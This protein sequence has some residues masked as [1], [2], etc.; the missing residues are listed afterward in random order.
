MRF[1][2]GGVVGL[3]GLGCLPVSDF[4]DGGGTTGAAG[5]SE[6]MSVTSNVGVTG[7]GGVTGE[8]PG[9]TSSSS[10]GEAMPTTAE[11]TC[12][13]FICGKEDL[14]PDWCDV[15]AQDCPEGQ[16]C[17]PVI[18][19]GGGAWDSVR[20]VPVLGAGMP[21]DACTAES[22][23]EGLDSCAEGV[24]CWGVDMDGNGTCVAQCTGTPDAPTCPDND[25]CTIASLGYLTL[26]LPT[27]DPLLQ[28]CDEGEACYPVDDGFTCDPDASGDTGKAND[29]CAFFNA[30]DPGLLCG[31]R[32]F[33]GAGCPQGSM[34]CCT[35]FCKFPDGACAN[36]DQ[37]CVQW[38]D[39]MMLPEGD[40]LLDIGACGVAS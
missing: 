35:P 8:G 6:G 14:P 25:I 5:S 19:D 34:G 27:C 2:L 4:G 28:D 36:P 24:I 21:G 12:G 10:T 13:A 17:M 32:V 30:C 22:V 1:L 29:P 9:G 11:P 20:C 40:P 15:F 33:V 26:C 16:K 7:T 39:P 18:S 37:E 38:F 23:A 3:G 31:D